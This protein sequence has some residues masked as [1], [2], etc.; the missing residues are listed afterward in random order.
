MKANQEITSITG[1]PNFVFRPNLTQVL[2]A[3]ASSN[4]PV[5]ASVVSGNATITNNVISFT[6]AG[7]VVV[8]YAQ[9]GDNL[10]NA[11]TS[12]ERTYVVAKANQMI[13]LTSFTNPMAFASS[14]TIV[15]TASSGLPVS[16]TALSGNAT[17]NGLV[18]T[19]TAGNRVELQLTQAGNDNYNAADPVVFSVNVIPT[20]T[21]GTISGTKFCGGAAVTVTYTVGGAFSPNNRVIAYLSDENGVFGNNR[22]LIGTLDALGSGT[23]VGTIP[24]NAKDGKG[25]KVR[26]EGIFPYVASAASSSTLE[27]NALPE[28]AFVRQEGSDL[29]SSVASG[30]Q[31]FANGVAIAGATSQKYKPTAAQAAL[32]NTL[33]S[34]VV[35]SGGGCT[36]VSDAVRY[37]AIPLGIDNPAFSAKLS[38]YPNPTV[39][40]FTVELGL[41]KLGKV[42]IKLLD[43]AGKLVVSENIE[44]TNLNF[45]HEINMTN[46]ASGVYV[47]TLTTEGK[48]AVKRIVKQ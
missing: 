4:L 10:W 15:T 8:R 20:L 19:P 6:T 47:M 41:E 40:K 45:K 38:V 23:I 32:P 27:I 9:A 17:V 7:T 46:Y 16:M 2:S 30:V 28:T 37:S 13:T 14:Q 43:A 36:S 5:V 35:T 48:T 24:N 21:V 42:S 26:V 29:V 25:Y 11:A 3:S 1:F 18:L 33:Y 34:V 31:W 22:G 44:A 39:D 12:V